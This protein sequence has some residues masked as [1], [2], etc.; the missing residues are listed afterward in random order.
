[1][2]VHP[3]TLVTLLS[4][5]YAPHADAYLVGSPQFS[6]LWASPGPP[7][8]DPRYFVVASCSRFDPATPFARL[9]GGVASAQLARGGA[10][11]D[12]AGVF[13]FNDGSLRLPPTPLA[14]SSLLDA[15]KLKALSCRS[16]GRVI[17]V[18][19][20]A[21]KAPIIEAALKAGLFNVLVTDANT[22]RA[23]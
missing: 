21:D 6:D 18:A 4:V 8:T 11:G 22:A 13:L 20:G 17:L 19:G 23:L 10:I 9:L 12:L 7:G 15:D 5:L 2:H 1:L 16:D 14:S 3:N